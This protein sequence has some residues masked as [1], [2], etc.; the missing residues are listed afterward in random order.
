MVVVSGTELLEELVVV[1]VLAH[2]LV[3]PSNPLL[4]IVTSSHVV[5]VSG[6]ELLEEL[7]VVVVVLIGL[8][9]NGNVRLIS[10]VWLRLHG[11]GSL[12]YRA[13]VG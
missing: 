2:E 11:S 4:E 8:R 5:V 3:P 9:V 13:A 6:T 7:V 1:V 10:S 12:E